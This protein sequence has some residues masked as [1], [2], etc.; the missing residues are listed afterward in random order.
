LIRN[1]IF[2]GE[3]TERRII[4]YNV[5]INAKKE[6]DIIS[7]TLCPLRYGLLSNFRSGETRRLSEPGGFNQAEVIDDRQIDRGEKRLLE[8]QVFIH[9]TE[10]IIRAKKIKSS[11]YANLRSP[12]EIDDRQL[13]NRNIE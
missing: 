13:S 5:R 3:S 1:Y 2:N 8:F 10:R 4:N 9:L 11:G 12:R 6:K 7:R